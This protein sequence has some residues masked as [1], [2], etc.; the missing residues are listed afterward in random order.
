MK[1]SV[2][3]VSY[4]SH[5]FIAQTIE[6]VLA[7]DHPDFEY[8]IIDGGSTDGTV[9]LIRSYAEKE[10][11]IRWCSEP[12]EGISD[13]MNK[14]A[15]M[16]L[17]DVITHLNSDD[18]YAHGWVL[19]RV[20]DAM[21]SMSTPGW[22]T[23]GFNF[24]SET[25]A[26]IREIRVRRYSFRRLLRGNILLHPATFID[27]GLFLAVG[28][29]D[30]SLHYCMDYDLFLRLGK[31]CPPYLLNE[32]LACFR[33]HP[34]SRSVSQSESAYAEEYRVRM[35]FLEGMGRTTWF[36]TMDYQIKRQLNKI[37]YSRLL[38]SRK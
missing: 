28:G 16:A 27:R 24:V 2:V 5:K 7:Q 9:E 35:K 17:G 38:T 32:Q 37:F 19:S 3:T 1:L 34:N 25:G 18:Y 33:A 30:T 21:L 15:S 10:Q 20:S 31:V 29:F 14:G 13:A 6:S 22:L 12:D 11:R 8:I 23:A 4:N 26:F 36:Y